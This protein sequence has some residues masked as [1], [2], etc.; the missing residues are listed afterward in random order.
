MTTL[1]EKEK[2]DFATQVA[3]ITEQNA[4]QLIDAGF[5]PATRVSG[6]RTK[7]TTADEAEG[8]QK[9]V[10]AAALDATKASNAALK[11]M[12]DDASAFVSLIEGLLGKDNSLVRKLK[13]LRK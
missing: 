13:Q 5:D 12:Y 7:I 2:R 8:T 6:L 9:E 3:V 4:Q 1:N 10:Q 11:D